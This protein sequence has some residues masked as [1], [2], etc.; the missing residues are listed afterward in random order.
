MERNGV[1]VVHEARHRGPNLGAVGIVFTALSLASVAAL[2][3]PAGGGQILSPFDAPGAAQ[4]SFV[5]HGMALRVAAFLGFGAAIPLGIFTA[6]AVSRLEFLGVNVAG[7]FISLFGGLAAS[8]M[9]MISALGQWALGQPGVAAQA[10][11]S[12]MLHLLMFATGGVGYVAAL[13][14]LLAGV[15]VI[16]LFM[17]TLPRWVTWLGLTIAAVAEVSSLSLLVP[18]AVYLLPLAR[19]PA[20]VWIIAAGFLLPRSRAEA[21]KRRTQPAEAAA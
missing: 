17:K 18:G 2:A 11:A 20:Y 8:V 9:L 3:I 1:E 7:V 5:A 13:G 21:R 12:R 15:S 4:A 14:L 6:T 16:S 19:F 10:G